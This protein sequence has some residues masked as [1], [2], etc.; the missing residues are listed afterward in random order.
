MAG[1]LLFRDGLDT[2]SVEGIPVTVVEMPPDGN[3]RTTSNSIDMASIGMTAGVDAR[4]HQVYRVIV[5]DA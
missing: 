2:M 5:Y 3:Y 1:H 4:C